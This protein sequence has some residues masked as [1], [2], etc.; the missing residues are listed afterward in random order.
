MRTVTKFLSGF[1]LGSLVGAAMALLLAPSSGD[2]LR[3]QMQQE[4]DRIQAEVK[5]AAEDRRIELEQQL[6]A[7]RA[8]RKAT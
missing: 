8:P 7:L 3:N 1:A 4:V 6:T 2:E 5:Q